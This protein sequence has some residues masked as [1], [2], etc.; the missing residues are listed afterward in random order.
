MTPRKRKSRIYWRRRG[1]ARRAYGDFRDYADVGG[2]REPLIPVGER[3]ATTDPDVA[4]KLAAERL[5]E[6]EAGRRRRALT[7]RAE[8]ATLAE[9]AAAYLVARK[10]AGS[11]TVAWLAACE[12]FL[13][14]ATK[15]FRRRQAAGASA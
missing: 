15:F 4:T 7:G 2:R 3:F 13:E 11:V 5:A 10:R 1:G 9:Q 12:G 14:R 6:L 8:I